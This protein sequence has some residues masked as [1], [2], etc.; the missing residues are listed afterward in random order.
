MLLPAFCLL[1]QTILLTGWFVGYR[2]DDDGLAKPGIDVTKTSLSENENVEVTCDIPEKAVQC[3]LYRDGQHVPMKNESGKSGL[4]Q[5]HV[6]AEE[7]H[8][9]NT[10][11]AWITIVRL[12]CAYS[13]GDQHSER[14]EMKEVK[15]LGVLKAPQLKIKP[16]VI[17]KGDTAELH[18]LVPPSISGCHFLI[19]GKLINLTSLECLLSYSW[20]D[21]RQTGNHSAD[22]EIEVQCLYSVLTD[23]HEAPSQHSNV[24]IVTLLGVTLSSTVHPVVTSENSTVDPVSDDGASFRP[25]EGKAASRTG[26]PSQP[27]R[28]ERTRARPRGAAEDTHWN[29]AG[30]VGVPCAVAAIL[31]GAAAV[32]LYRRHRNQKLTRQLPD[33]D[34]SVRMAE[35]SSDTQSCNNVIYSSIS[36]APTDPVTREEN[37]VPSM[38]DT[39]DADH[40]YATISEVSPEVSPASIIATTNYSTVQQQ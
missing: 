22:T 37:K 5:F 14:S 2:S 13:V 25:G 8:H 4:C 35:P 36:D 24:S 9:G 15:V 27:G 33:H 32:F 26:N 12:S 30:T 38:I 19:G 31:L 28:A 29:K 1:A 7:L 11:M 20:D 21:L 17:R 10:D 6:T 23:G 16:N 18:C 40:C 3:S 39:P 34:A